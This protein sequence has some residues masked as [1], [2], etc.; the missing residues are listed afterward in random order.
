MK[1]EDVPKP[2]PPKVAAKK[3]ALSSEKPVDKPKTVASSSK[4]PSAPVVQ[5]EDL[6]GGLSA[7][8]AIEKVRD[9]FSGGIIKNFEEAKW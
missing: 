3:P 4:G 8:E 2:P 7:E 9:N 5:E 6:G 1:D